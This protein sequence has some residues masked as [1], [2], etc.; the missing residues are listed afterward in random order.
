M[1]QAEHTDWAILATLTSIFAGSLVLSA[2]L[3]AKIV[4]VFGLVVPAGVFGYCLTF[5]CT[6]VIS[7]VWGRDIAKAAVRGG[8]VALLA[9]LG[10][11]QL[12]LNWPSAAFWHGQEAFRSVL[13]MTPRIIIGSIAAYL[14]SQ[15]HDVWAFHF[16]RR[17]TR[18]RHLWLRNNLSTALS[19]LLDSFVFISIGFAGVMPLA[20]LIFGQWAVKLLIALL[21][22]LV[23]YILVWLIRD[24]ANRGASA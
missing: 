23:V 11:I 20:P 21:D 8:F 12:A 4:T 6:D 17:L 22:T 5:I 16:L 18:G 10:L 13:S 15:Y 19:Q 1:R 24:R 9:A 14:I 2:V 7:E 3:A